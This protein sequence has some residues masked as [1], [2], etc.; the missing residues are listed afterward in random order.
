M[1]LKVSV[2]QIPTGNRRW[3]VNVDVFRKYRK[4]EKKKKREGK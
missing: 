4:R 2:K 1:S 3:E